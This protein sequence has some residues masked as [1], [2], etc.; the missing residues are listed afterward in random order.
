MRELD[1]AVDLALRAGKKLAELYN[2]RIIVE[3][4]HKIDRTNVTE[5]DLAANKIILE[6]LEDKFPRPIILSGETFSPEEKARLKSD[7]V[8]LIDP[9]DG[10]Y[11]FTHR[12]DDFSVII[13]YT[14]KGQPIAAVM[15]LPIHDK[16][17]TA[18]ALQGAYLTE[19][20]V[21]RELHV[22]ERTMEEAV[23]AL[24]RKEFNAEKADEIRQ[25][26]GMKSFIQTGSMGVKVGLIAEGKA[27]LYINSNSNA[28]EWDAA[29]PGLIIVEAGG[30]I[31]DYDGNILQYNKE[32]PYLRKGA[33]CSNGVV[34][35]SALEKVDEIFPL[36]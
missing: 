10:L 13:A 5:A 15:Y 16:L 9:L 14:H 26:M 22:S 35:D 32:D 12:T 24:S 17:Y 11:D 19:K 34:H 36:K 27:D 8:W 4:W 1:V 2:K 30:R 20:G 33:I 29:G 31:S 23:I 3:Q 18:K 7:D 21:T 28:G 25:K 6:G